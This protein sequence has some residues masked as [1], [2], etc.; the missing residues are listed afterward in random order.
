M[1]N[2][3]AVGAVKRCCIKSNRLMHA[4]CIFIHYKMIVSHQQSTM[5]SAH[6]QRTD[7]KLMNIFPVKFIKVSMCVFEFHARQSIFSP[8]HTV[9]FQFSINSTPTLPANNFYTFRKKCIQI[10]KSR[11]LFWNTHFSHNNRSWLIPSELNCIDQK[12]QHAV[13]YHKPRLHTFTV[14]L[15]L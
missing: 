10:E 9:E 5:L 15:S 2:W 13:G 1:F 3:H 12:F 6:V 11:S 14:F 8:Y 4:L 7:S